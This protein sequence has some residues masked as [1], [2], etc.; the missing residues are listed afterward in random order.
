MGLLNIFRKKN[1]RLETPVD[2]SLLGCDI[3]SHLIPNI[4]D[5]SKSIEDSISMIT[6]FYNLG[7]KKIITTPHI[8]GDA[9]RNTPETILG[10]LE[11]VKKALKEN[12]LPVDRSAAAEYYL[13]FDFER[14]LDEGKLLTFGNNYLLFE[15]SYLNPPDNMYH[16]IFKMQT[17]GYKPVLAHPERYNF[18]HGE[19]ET[20]ESIA[21]KGVLLQLNINSL[22]GYYSLGTKKIA[23]LMI[24]KNMIS[25]LGTDCHHEGH[26]NLMKQVVYE[27]Y[28]QKLMESG[29]LLNSTL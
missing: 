4:D 27:P 16:V 17:M 15:I 2:L 11:N 18:W 23:E 1:K 9:Y 7:Y 5:G 10:G 28:L 13:D 29:K 8:M 21:D 24:E 20:Y 19:F 25:M 14:K 12:N 6:E 3:H 26:I 22:S